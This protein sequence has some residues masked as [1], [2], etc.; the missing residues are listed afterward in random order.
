MRD[1][2]IILLLTVLLG[3]GCGY[4]EYWMATRLEKKR[5]LLLLQ[6]GLHAVIAV[7]F[8]VWVLDLEE[9]RNS[10]LRFTPLLFAV[11]LICTLI[12]WVAGEIRRRRK[13]QS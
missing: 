3:V 2:L 1:P 6:P 4:F 13:D 5:W 12:G 9:L 11:L 10:T 7:C 8:G